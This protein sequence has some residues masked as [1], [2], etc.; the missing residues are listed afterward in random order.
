MLDLQ[1]LVRAV[2]VGFLLVFTL[3]VCFIATTEQTASERIVDLPAFANVRWFG[4][5]AVAV[6]GLCAA[7]FLRR[8]KFYLPIATAAFSLAFWTGSRGAIVAPFAGFLLC[9]LLFREFRSVRAWLLLP[10]AALAGLALASALDALDPMGSSGSAAI[11]R[12]GSTGRFDLWQYAIR[13][14]LERPWLGHGEGQ[15][16]FLHPGYTV[17]QSHNVVLQVLYTWGFVGALLC[18]G[19]AIWVALRYLREDDGL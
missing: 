6:I 3:L 5:F 11:A 4:E 2:T 15:F 19:L 9:T 10:L 12:Y 13:E 18:L 1:R 7:G 17:V 14:I 8:D 16:Q